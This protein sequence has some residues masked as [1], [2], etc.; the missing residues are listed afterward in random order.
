MY[1]K[2]FQ[3]SCYRVL[4]LLLKDWH[5]SSFVL[6]DS[7]SF[8]ALTKVALSLIGPICSCFFSSKYGRSNQGSGAADKGASKNVSSCVGGTMIRGRLIVPISR[9]C[10]KWPKVRD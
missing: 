4:E 9:F 5:F 7:G 2:S 8:A 1:T 3:S 6:N 10:K